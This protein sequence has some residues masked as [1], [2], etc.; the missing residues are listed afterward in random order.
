M[1]TDITCRCELVAV[2]YDRERRLLT[3]DLMA[4]IRVK[5]DTAELFKVHYVISIQCKK[6]VKIF[7]LK[8]ILNSLEGNVPFYEG[9]EENLEG[10][11]VKAAS[12]RTPLEKL[13]D[14]TSVYFSDL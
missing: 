13:P 3:S 6:S 5:M 2:L 1:L 14:G 7:Q 9:S 8:M 4:S 10:E 12:E 11:L